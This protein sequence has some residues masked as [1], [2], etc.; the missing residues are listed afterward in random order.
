[1]VAETFYP[2][3]GFGGMMQT[4]HQFMAR[5]VVAGAKPQYAWFGALVFVVAGLMALGAGAQ[6]VPIAMEGG[7]STG[8]R[9][10][11]TVQRE[12]DGILTLRSSGRAAATTISG[13]NVLDLTLRISPGL[14]QA[15]QA[16]HQRQPWPPGAEAGSALRNGNLARHLVQRRMPW[17]AAQVFRLGDV[18]LQG[19]EL[20]I[21]MA[22]LEDKLGQADPGEAVL[23]L[24]RARRM[25]VPAS[26]VRADADSPLPL[27][28][29]RLT[30]RAQIEAVQA[31]EQAWAK[32]MA[33]HAPQTH[34]IEAQHFVIYTSWSKSND[35]ALIEIYDKLYARLIDQFGLRPGENLFIGKLPVYAFWEQGDFVRFCVE[36]VGIPHDIAQLAGGFNSVRGDFNAVVLGPVQRPG[37]T[38]RQARQWFFELLVHESTHAFLARYLNGRPIPSWLNE[39]IAE[40]IAAELVPGAYANRKMRDAHRMLA[41]GTGA[42]PELMFH[43]SNIPLD[44]YY[45]GLAQSYTRFLIKQGKDPFVELVLRIKAGE[46]D[47]DALRA[48]YGRS[49]QELMQRWQRALR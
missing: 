18:E 34:R 48:V 12:R 32:I 33:K 45:Y 7:L 10:A 27:R 4:G 46:T 14:R 36:A 15:L 41:A 19:D 29:Y 23:E 28:R 21:D 13:H 22:A 26:L 3:L 11:G 2:S 35:K 43:G 6:S 5:R 38:K 31:Q 39:G 1:M 25:D 24:Y 8:E 20:A 49:R 40:T 30:S 16:E 44:S 47:D 42:S 9:F 17:L 37:M